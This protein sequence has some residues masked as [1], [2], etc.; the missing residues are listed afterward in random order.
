MRDKQTIDAASSSK[1]V[2]PFL[3]WAGGKRWLL[4]EL[5]PMIERV[6]PANY[7]E[8]FLGGGAVFLGL[9][10]GGSARLSDLNADLIETYQRVRDDPDGVA[11]ILESHRNES[12]YYYEIRSLEPQ[13]P[14]QRAA[15]FIFLNHTSFNGIYRVNLKGEYN[16][17]FGNRKSF[18]IPSREHLHRVSAALAGTALETEDFS[19][20]LSAV[21]QG[22]LVFLDPPYTVAH[23]HNGF[24]KYNDK[25]FAFTDQE[26]LS[27]V[28]DAVRGRGA[29]YILT[30][31][32]HT[33]IETLFT[34]D[35]D[36]RATVHRKNV[37]GG[38]KAVRGTAAEYLFTNI[39]SGD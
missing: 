39:P 32:A 38:A 19:S 20:F 3:R 13:C 6:S 12:D 16:V 18:R 28:I 22:D 31:A 36:M 11:D 26:R 24:V 29:Y 1:P 4:P 7:F 9:R 25:L 33:S 21:Q 27:K 15:R 30:N 2:A 34:R 5:A 10:P 35:G 23:N 14:N 37:I 8:P 17:P